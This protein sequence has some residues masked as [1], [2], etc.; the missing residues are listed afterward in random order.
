MPQSIT[1]QPISKAALSGSFRAWGVRREKLTGWDV[2][3]FSVLRHEEA[4]RLDPACLI[5]LYAGLGED[6][7]ERVVGLAMEELA[8]CLTEVD[9]HAPAGDLPALIRCAERV[10]LVACDI[11]MTTLARVAGDVIRAT[12]TGDAAGRAATVARLARIGDR[13]FAAI[14]DIRDASL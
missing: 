8:G 3:V 5:A 6:R 11:G 4:I 1:H 12:I 10:S 7:A 13:S 2:A 9:R 14:W